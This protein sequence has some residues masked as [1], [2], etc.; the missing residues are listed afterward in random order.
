M[1]IFRL[2]VTA[3]LAVSSITSQAIATGWEA[4]NATDAYAAYCKFVVD[5]QMQP[6][7]LAMANAA[8][9]K[10]SVQK[11]LL[12]DKRITAY[13]NARPQL[14]PRALAEASRKAA[15]DTSLLDRSCQEDQCFATA[16]SA[17]EALR[18]DKYT[19]CFKATQACIEANPI[20]KAIQVRI[21]GCFSPDWPL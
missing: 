5:Q 17:P 18:V 20:L 19:A 11:I 3:T 1:K 14:D 8:G 21:R 7:N 13:L 4:P 6:L 15:S 10:A 2:G 9:G 16:A 12:A